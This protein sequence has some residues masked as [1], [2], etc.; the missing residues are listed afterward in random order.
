MNAVT[1]IGWK[2]RENDPGHWERLIDATTYCAITNYSGSDDYC[3]HAVRGSA[4]LHG[5]IR[6]HESAMQKA[7]EVIAIPIEEFN[8]LAVEKLLSELL[9]LER[10][11]L[12]LA[13]AAKVLPGYAS[14]YEAGAADTKRRIMAA[15][16]Q[17]DKD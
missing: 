15:I 7:D 11:I 2:Q 17:E 9:E 1:Q 16:E 8:E 5:L 4:R 3:W 14:G 10:A 12:L 13:P 6:G